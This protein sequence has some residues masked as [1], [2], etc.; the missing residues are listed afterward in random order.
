MLIASQLYTTLTVWSAFISMIHTSV[1][2][3]LNGW[4]HGD[5]VIVSLADSIPG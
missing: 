4:S 1:L 2:D 3:T 5:S